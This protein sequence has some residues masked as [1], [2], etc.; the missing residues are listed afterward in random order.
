MQ[1]N[2]APIPPHPISPLFPLLPLNIPLLRPSHLC[3]ITPPP[4]LAFAR[5]LTFA[6]SLSP[7]YHSP[8]SLAFARLLSLAF[9]RPSLASLDHHK[10]R[11]VLE[12]AREK[13]RQRSLANDGASTPT[14]RGSRSGS[15]PKSAGRS[16]FDDSPPAYLNS[17]VVKNDI[18]SDYTKK[19]SERDQQARAS[20]AQKQRE[21]EE[22][23]QW[24]RERKAMQQHN[25][26]QDRAWER[27]VLEDSAAEREKEVSARRA[28]KVQA[29]QVRDVA[30]RQKLKDQLRRKEE[31][32][33]MD[34][35]Q[36]GRLQ[37]EYEQSKE[38]GAEWERQA[39]SRDKTELRESIYRRQ[40]EKDI[41][42]TYDG[43]R[44]SP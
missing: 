13:R 17:S 11:P 14:G 43:G 23:Q 25:A 21:R 19:L 42:D 20:R 29:K 5:R 41:Y 32:T 26:D 9:A 37:E 44:T 12:L 2:L 27:R 1:R 18:R 33:Q 36:R 15:S 8:L 34:S 39:K 28:S 30:R 7:A 35:E 38:E 3:G 4:S 40:E 6:H 16:R 10:I 31:Q 22:K 24:W